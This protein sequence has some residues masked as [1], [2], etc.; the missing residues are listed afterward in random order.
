M[1]P[2]TRKPPAVSIASR[3][4]TTA[5]TTPGKRPG[6]RK[7][8]HEAHVSTQQ[9]KEK[10]D[11]RVPG[12]DADARRA[13]RT[14]TPTLQGTEAPGSLSL[15]AGGGFRFV[16]ADRLLRRRDFLRVYDQGRR[17]HQR[18]F[19]LFYL[20]GEAD[21]HRIGLTVPRKLGNAVHR[22]RVKRRLREIFR[23][24][25]DWLGE[26]PL[27]LVVNVSAA[28]I[29]ATHAELQEGFSRAAA[30]ARDGRG[31]PGRRRGQKRR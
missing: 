12:A 27:D 28:G 3:F 1:D 24:H 17:V 21:R 23:V 5:G 6:A 20:R 2:E 13:S 4:M 22:N 7:F 11:A 14:G 10:K 16:P 30:E 29:A 25:R 8:E 18:T 15:A 26:T 9:S 31:S 19:L